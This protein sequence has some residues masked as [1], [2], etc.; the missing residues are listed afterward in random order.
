MIA[1]MTAQTSFVSCDPDLSTYMITPPSTAVTT[2]SRQR[3]PHWELIVVE[4]ASQGKT[5][6]IVRKFADDHPRH[7]VVYFRS[8]KN[9]GPSH[10]QARPLTPVRAAFIAAQA[11]VP[12]YALG[13]VNARNAALLAPAFSGIAAISSLL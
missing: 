3:Y 10:S 6:G 4:D 5:E 11:P 8:E 13:G 2:I 1:P 12:V 9:S 7:R